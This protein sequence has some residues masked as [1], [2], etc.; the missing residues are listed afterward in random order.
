MVTP[1]DFPHAFALHLTDRILLL[2]ARSAKEKSIWVD[3]FR[4][5]IKEHKEAKLANE[6]EENDEMKIQ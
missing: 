2:W 4:D 5:M 6:G 1:E 3:A